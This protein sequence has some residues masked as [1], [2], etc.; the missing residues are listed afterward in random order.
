MHEDARKKDIE[1]NTSLMVGEEKEDEFHLHQSRETTKAKYQIP[2]Q[3]VAGEIFEG[4]YPPDSDA[5]EDLLV[6]TNA[7]STTMVNNSKRG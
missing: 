6:N 5:K 3:M 2:L 4:Q 1:S 7:E